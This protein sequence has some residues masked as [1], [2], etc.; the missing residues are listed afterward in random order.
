MLAIL[1]PALLQGFLPEALLNAAK[2]NEFPLLGSCIDI[3]AQLIAALK[4]Q[5]LPEIAVVATAL[6]PT[7]LDELS[8]LL[9]IAVLSIPLSIALGFLLYKPLYRGV[10]R[11]ALLY[12]SH[13]LVSVMAAWILYRQFYF[14]YLIEGVLMQKL[15]DQA[16]LTIVSFI[17]Q[18]F[19]AAAIGAL[20]VKALLTALATRIVIGKIIMPVIGTLI[21]TLLFAFL[22]ALMLLLQ[23]NPADCIPALPLMLLTL[24]L[25]GIN[26]WI[27]GC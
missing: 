23:S 9:M 19:S 10:I 3:A 1:S 25:S 2:L 22:I 5:S 26:D 7:F 24:I 15:T 17:T 14:K 13:N 6:G 16:A 27:F 11:R 4:Q 12:I 21:R 8:S 20:A 18:L